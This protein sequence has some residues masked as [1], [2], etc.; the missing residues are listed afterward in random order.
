MFRLRPRS[1]T[2]YGED[3]L[4]EDLGFG[5]ENHFAGGD[6]LALSTTDAADEAAAHNGV[7]AL[8]QSEQP[9]HDLREEMHASSGFRHWGVEVRIL[10]FNVME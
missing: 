9:E 7:R 1:A 4:I 3:E 5:P 10:S 6:A 2:H 8:V